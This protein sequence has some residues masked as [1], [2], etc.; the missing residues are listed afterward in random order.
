M[1]QIEMVARYLAARPNQWI[2]G[3]ELVRLAS[4]V[5]GSDYIIQDADTRAYEL[6]KEGFNSSLFK[7]TFD[8]EK[9]GKYAYFRCTSKTR[10]THVQGLKD[11]TFAAT[12]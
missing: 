6:A 2:A 4:S 12:T 7:Y 1:R 11:W 5:I 3:H 10:H 8:T 9:R